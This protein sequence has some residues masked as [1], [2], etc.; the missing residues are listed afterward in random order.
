MSYVWQ[1]VG[2]DLNAVPKIVSERERQLEALTNKLSTKVLDSYDSFSK[3][4]SNNTK[5]QMRVGSHVSREYFN[6]RTST[7]Y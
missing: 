1:V 7:S 3:Y 2:E 5:L 6:S 4:T